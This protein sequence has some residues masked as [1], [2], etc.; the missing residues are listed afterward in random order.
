MK[1]AKMVAQDGK[2][3]FACTG[4]QQ[5]IDSW[6]ARNQAHWDLNYPGMT[7]VIEEIVL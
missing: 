1:I 4:T 6:V 3:K 5:E 2:I 7:L